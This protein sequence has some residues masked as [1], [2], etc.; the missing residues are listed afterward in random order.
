MRARVGRGPPLFANPAIPPVSSC[1]PLVFEIVAREKG[2]L[3]MVYRVRFSDKYIFLGF[4]KHY[5]K[6]GIDLRTL[7]NLAAEG[8]GFPSA[9]VYV[10]ACHGDV[11]A[12]ESEMRGR[13]WLV[14]VLAM[15]EK[16]LVT[17]CF[18]FFFLPSLSRSERHLVAGLD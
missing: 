13:C 11:L 8:P 3:R 12:L 2:A 10:R 9:G 7:R 4:H 17:E 14:L 6:Y 16:P 15:R 18:L 5:S 1:R